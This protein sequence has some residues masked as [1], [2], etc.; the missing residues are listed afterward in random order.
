MWGVKQFTTLSDRGRFLKTGDLARYNADG[1][2]NLLGRKDSE[3]K[4]RGQR[5]N[6]K[7]V[8]ILMRPQLGPN[9]DIFVES[10]LPKGSTPTLAAFL[11][12]KDAHSLSSKS[13]DGHGFAAHPTSLSARIQLVDSPLQTSLPVDMVPAVY[14][15]VSALPTSISGKVD[16]RALTERVIALTGAEL[17]TLMHGQP[18]EVLPPSTPM[19]KRLVTLIA[20]TPQ[21]ECANIAVNASFLKL[22]GDSHRNGLYI[23]PAPTIASLAQ[24]AQVQI[25]TKTID[26]DRNSLFGLTPMQRHIL[27]GERSPTGSSVLIELQRQQESCQVADAILSL[28]I[29][30]PMLRS[31]F[32]VLEN[33]EVRQMMMDAVDGGLLFGEREIKLSEDFETLRETGISLLDP[34]KGPVVG[35]YLIQSLGGKQMLLLVAHDLIVDS[36]SWVV[37]QSD[38]EQLL[39]ENTLD[40]V[41][42]FQEWYNLIQG[43]AKQNDILR[44]LA[45]EGWAGGDDDSNIPIYGSSLK[46][47]RGQT[48]ALDS[49][50]CHLLFGDVRELLQ[51][52]PWQIILA[53]LA[54]SY[55]LVF[56]DRRPPSLAV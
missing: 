21:L 17:D 35:V 9:F 54:R 3:V 18:A 19:E 8:E 12:A 47:L 29:Q 31:R 20:D 15:L 23:F 11:F 49:E 27:S 33:G 39:G 40:E 30:H 26:F 7:E 38:L 46:L 37:L 44:E 50:P 56:P 41:P 1:T 14:L 48:A 2:I 43:K 16:R 42:S 24:R 51:V 32:V 6:L 52:Q 25:D 4:I 55:Y 34:C 10:V 36:R 13:V 5:V 22:G 28:V 53:A 45:S